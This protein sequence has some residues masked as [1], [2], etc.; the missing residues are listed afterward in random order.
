[1]E[2]FT[3][4]SEVIRIENLHKTYIL[5][6]QQVNALDGVSLSIRKND[7]IAIMGP[8]G[9]GK[10]T[11]MNILGCLD[12]PTSGKYILGG[13]DVSQ[14][15]DSDLADVR[16]RQIGFVFQSF[17]LL[18]RYS[19]LENVALP[20]IYCGTPE[21]E[22]ISLGTKALEVVGLS[23]RMDHKPNELSGGQRQRV[24]IARAIL[25]NPKLLILDE[26]TSALDTESEF[27][28]QQALNRLTS[29]R[30]TFAIAHRLSTL[31][32]ANRLI[33]IDKHS[34]AEMG[35]HN[36]LLEKKGIYYG[37]VTAQLKMAEG[38]PEA[39]ENTAISGE[40]TAAT[41]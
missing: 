20:L 10:S 41:A 15:E 40:K 32:E 2:E 23:D 8:S 30:T 34:I 37:L 18:P 14:M 28:I 25:N 9:S 38:R 29:G 24:A 6:T 36:E 22:R 13:T 16:N 21:K 3:K 27:L 39:T 4:N 35:S 1:M 26:A 33:V 31:R 5:G 11:M 17:N 19:A 12:T 7:Y